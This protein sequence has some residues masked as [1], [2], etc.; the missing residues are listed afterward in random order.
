MQQLQ[1]T[2]GKSMRSG[3]EKERTSGGRGREVPEFSLINQGPQPSTA[4]V[5]TVKT[6]LTPMHPGGKGRDRTAVYRP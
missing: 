5:E 1:T 6:F 3:G 4:Q 2:K